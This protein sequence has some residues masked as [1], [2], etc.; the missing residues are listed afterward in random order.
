MATLLGSES[1][2]A[3]GK[4]RH[5]NS[6]IVAKFTASK[7]TGQG[8]SRGTELPGGLLQERDKRAKWH[9]IPTLLQRLYESSHP[10][11]DLSNAHS[12][13]KVLSSQLSMEAMSFVT[14]DRKTAQESTF[15][16]T[17][18][19]DLFGGVDLLVE[20][21]M[22]PTLTMQKKKKNLND[23]LVKDCLSVLYNC[24]IC[25]E[26]VT[27]SLAARD[28]FVLFLFTLMTNKKTFLQTATLI[29]DILGVKKEMIHLEG[30]PNLSGLVQSFDQQQLANF[31]RILSVTI[32][33][34]DVGND[35]KHTLLAKNAQ[36]KSIA[37]PSR[38]ERLCKLA[39]RK[40]SEAT[41]ANFLQEL[42]DWY[43]WLDNALVLDALMQMA[44]EEAEQ[45]STG[46]KR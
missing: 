33:E 44:T 37:S 21:L 45:S 36:Q 13:L 42:E 25:T 27:K 40:V 14:E 43:T 38:A 34:P 17:Y 5:C 6:S 46:E 19:F 23:D 28:D 18:T 24:C 7:I 32:S 41:G 22:R 39:T 30:I 26:G 10:N 35:D 29:E 9:G 3:A 20:I 8:F 16:N 31:C 15:P 12:F 1:P 11:S 4:R 2:C